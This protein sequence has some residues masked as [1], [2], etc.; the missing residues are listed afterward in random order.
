MEVEA[1]AG[2][3]PKHLTP[4]D[5]KTGLHVIRFTE[6][7]TEPFFVNVQVRL[8][9]PGSNGKLA[10][11]PFLV[12]NAAEQKGTILV[13]APPGTLRG[14]RLIFH[15][16]G[17]KAVRHN[18]PRCA[19]G[20][21]CQVRLRLCPGP[22]DRRGAAGNRMASREGTGRNLRRASGQAAASVRRASRRGASPQID[23]VTRI[24]VKSLSAGVD[25][26]DVQLPQRPTPERPLALLPFGPGTA[27]P[28][29]VPWAGLLDVGPRDVTL[30]V[31]TGFT[32]EDESGAPCEMSAPDPQGKVRI[33]F[34]RPASGKELFLTLKGKYVVPGDAHRLRLELPHP[35]GILDRGGKATISADEQTELLVGS[36]IV[37]EPVAIGQ[38]AVL[39]WEEGQALLDSWRPYRPPFPADS[40][41][42]VT[43][44]GKTAHVRQQL[45]VTW[46]GPMAGKA[47][48][49]RLRVPRSIRKLE[50]TSG[51]KLVSFDAGQGTALVEPA[52]D[53][54]AGSRQLRLVVEFSQ[55][56]PTD[57]A[58][59]A[60]LDGAADLAGRFVAAR[61]VGARLERAGG[62]A[63]GRA[64]RA[65]AT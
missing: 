1:P 8:P 4:F 15:T 60:H 47:G 64:G 59:R 6:G 57:D 17:D 13:Q 44:Q 24:R 22:A 16:L 32:C 58:E 55:S 33:K 31:P 28:A 9:R 39:P 49:L 48:L 43:L 26:L 2:M 52:T 35:L 21:D 20:H 51:G 11:G 5:S 56:L 18:V 54:G 37:A 7:H 29:T 30:A 45:T 12:Q 34:L 38:G 27:F 62:P 25:F 14:Q 42:D 19:G 41:T 63:P 10:I 61:C 36:A 23:A 40:I 3:A 50:I 53:G 65:M 46:P